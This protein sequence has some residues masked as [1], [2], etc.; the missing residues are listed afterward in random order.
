[1]VKILEHMIDESLPDGIG[2][3]NLI[4]RVLGDR[5]I[6]AETQDSIEKQKD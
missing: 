5:W 1:M 4:E 6:L 3:P 2:F